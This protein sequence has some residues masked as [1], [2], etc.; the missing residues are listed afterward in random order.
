MIIVEKH[1]E[2]ACFFI[3]LYEVECQIR[4]TFSLTTSI[5]CCTISGLIV[6]FGKMV[7]SGFIVILV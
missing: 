3:F 7:A 6:K 4:P 2:M 5:F 1:A